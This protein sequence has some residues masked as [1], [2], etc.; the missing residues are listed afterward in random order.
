MALILQNLRAEGAGIEPGSLLPGQLAF[1]LV[2][3]IVFVGDGTD[4]KTDFLG[5][6]VLGV[7]GQGWYAMPMDYDTFNTYFVANPEAYG[8]IPQNNDVLVWDGALN[9]P[10]W[11]PN[12]PGDITT[13]T[14]TAP[15][16][17]D[18]TNPQVPDI[19]VSSATTSSTGV[20]Q[21]NDSVSST[22]ITE[23]ATPNSVKTAF[24]AAVAAQATADAAL[25][26]AGGTMTGFI[27]FANNQLVDAGTF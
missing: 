8:D 7:P 11:L 16:T 5:T 23:A 6:Q 20:V 12:S 9:R 4:F 14:S 15:I 24:D 21:L 3:R 10:T 17:L 22:S 2:D 25:P 19:G 26:K 1:N 27:D 18:F 13:V